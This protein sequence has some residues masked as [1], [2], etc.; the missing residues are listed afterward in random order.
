MDAVATN[1]TELEAAL[2]GPAPFIGLRRHFYGA[3]CVDP[4]SKFKSYTS[5][6]SQNPQSRR[7]NERHYKTMSFDELAA[8]PVKELAAPGGCHLFLWT[9]G[10]FLPQALQLIDAWGF[11]YSTRAF[12][13]LKTRRSWESGDPLLESDFTVGLGLT[14]RSQTELV[15]LA[16]RGNCRRQRK[17]VREFYRRVDV[18]QQEFRLIVH[19]A[20]RHKLAKANEAVARYRN[21]PDTDFHDLVAQWTQRERSTAKTTNFAKAYGA[22]VRTLAAKLGKSEAEARGIMDRYDHELPFVSQ[23]SAMCE[24]SVKRQGYLVL[25][26]GARRHWE[27]WAGRKMGKRTRAVPARRG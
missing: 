7:D 17:D 15:L 3:I 4:A 24:R 11:K 19:Y 27:N 21:D 20:A 13:W 1:A 6:Q 5:I 26:D 10:P 25:Y 22:G 2:A 18:S 14:T 16:R 9:S 8:L 12:T 23:L